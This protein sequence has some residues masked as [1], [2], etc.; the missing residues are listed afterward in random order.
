MLKPITNGWVKWHI[1]DEAQL[2]KLRTLKQKW[3]PSNKADSPEAMFNA[4]MRAMLSR[5]IKPSPY[6][7]GVDMG[8]APVELPPEKD[9]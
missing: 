7:I 1:Y 2:D 4:L 9:E 8:G 5:N 6:D 3:L